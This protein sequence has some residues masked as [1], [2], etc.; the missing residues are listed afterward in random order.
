ML[1]L[2]DVQNQMNDAQHKSCAF[3]VRCQYFSKLLSKLD[4]TGPGVN[5]PHVIFR[6]EIRRLQR[7]SPLQRLCEWQRSFMWVF[8]A[9]LLHEVDH[10]LQ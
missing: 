2:L 4:S 9:K 6:V 5:L 3:H 1:Q 8:G 7:G 10:M